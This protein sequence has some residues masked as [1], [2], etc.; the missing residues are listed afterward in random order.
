MFAGEFLGDKYPIVDFLV[1]LI[2]NEARCCF[3]D[4][5]EGSFWY[6]WLD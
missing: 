1:R 3:L 4:E 5:V 2:E 6:S